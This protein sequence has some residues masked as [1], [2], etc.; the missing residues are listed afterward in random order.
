MDRLINAIKNIFL[1]KFK[2]CE[3][4]FQEFIFFSSACAFVGAIFVLF[5]MWLVNVTLWKEL[6]IVVSVV[7]L[8][9]ALRFITNVKFIEIIVGAKIYNLIKKEERINIEAVS[10][11]IAS[12]F[13]LLAW[14]GLLFSTITID[15][16]KAAIAVVLLASFV[17]W[18]SGIAWDIK[19]KITQK[20]VIIHTVCVIVIYFFSVISPSI[21]L[22]YLGFDPYESSAKSELYNV[23]AETEAQIKINED[24]AKTKKMLKI[25]TKLKNGRA[26]FPDEKVFY[27]QERQVMKNNS[28]VNVLR[29][30]AKSIFHKEP[31]LQKL[32]RLSYKVD[33][34]SYGIQWKKKVVDFK[35]TR[36]RFCYN[37]SRLY[38]KAECEFWIYFPDTNNEMHLNPSSKPGEVRKAIFYD[39]P[40]NGEDIFIRSNKKFTLYYVLKL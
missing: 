14:Y 18:L 8:Y 22:Q 25:L 31:S 13:L 30:K 39:M 33:D 34:G 20:I 3:E 23:I 17:Y 5:I 11:N 12:F 24:K 32:E 36:F 15:R 35:K 10:K 7:A 37:G 29:D 16:N 21:Y 6:N 26:L 9:C 38:Y 19:T 1:I 40:K 4:N 2:K 27:E 28:V